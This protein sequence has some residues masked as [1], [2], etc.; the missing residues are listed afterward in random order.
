MG[1]PALTRGLTIIDGFIQS[2]QPQR[3]HQIKKMIE[4]ITDASLNRLI[5]SL[6]EDCYIIKDN[7]G[8]YQLS[9]KVNLWGSHL[10]GQK[11]WNSI[12]EE[13]IDKVSNDLGES[14]AIGVLENDR[15]IIKKSKSVQDSI[16]I[17]KNNSTLHF[18]SDHA[19]SLAIL[20]SVTITQRKK[21]IKSNYSSIKSYAEF[22]NAIKKFKRQD[23]FTDKSERRNGISRVSIS[24]TIDKKPAT[25]FIATT[26]TSLKEDF[27]LYRDTLRKYTQ[28]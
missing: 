16:T 26:T 15:I 6:I 17:M 24:F 5:Q 19:A 23:I 22:D 4:G 9:N 14:A 8:S 11:N 25:L 28:I 3:Y 10:S 20:D 1:I 7:D 27:P 21:L 18:E 13:L 12:M 2:A